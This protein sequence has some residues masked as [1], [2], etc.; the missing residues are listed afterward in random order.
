MIKVILEFPHTGDIENNLEYARLC[1]KDSMA[2][3]ESP[4]V[5]HLIY[6]QVLD[7]NIPQDRMR[8]IGIGLE[9]LDVADKHVFYVDY[10]WSQSMK[11]ALAYSYW[12]LT[13]KEF[14]T[15]L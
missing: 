2:R 8:G 13:K 14:R 7:D 3:D 5:S 15:I 1:I 6:T 4:I 11:E 9:W 10:G 12:I